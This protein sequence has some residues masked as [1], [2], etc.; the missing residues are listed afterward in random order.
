MLNLKTENSTYEFWVGLYPE[1][2]L[3]NENGTS[4]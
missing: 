2:I 1:N 3:K 4:K